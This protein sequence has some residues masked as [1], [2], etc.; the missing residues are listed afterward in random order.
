MKEAIESIRKVMK[1]SKQDRKRMGDSNRELFE[2]NYNCQVF[3]KAYI[4]L[5]D[6]L[7]C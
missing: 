1:M 2:K 7:E 5:I 3:A 4:R 6:E